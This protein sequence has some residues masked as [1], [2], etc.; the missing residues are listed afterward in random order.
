MKMDK[1]KK[2]P[3]IRKW[4]RC[5]VCGCKLLIYDNTTVC[6]NVFIKCRTCKKEVEI[7]I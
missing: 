7:K 3:L 2:P 4:Y 1:I 5:P 6:T